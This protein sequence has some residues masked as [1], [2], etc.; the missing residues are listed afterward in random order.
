[1]CS[2]L[3]ACSYWRQANTNRSTKGEWKKPSVQIQRIKANK[4]KT[5]IEIREG[6]TDYTDS[7]Q[8]LLFKSIQEEKP[9]TKSL[10]YELHLCVLHVV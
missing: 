5:F 2:F 9:D 6:K 10:P 1:M 7:K 4:K 3:K 8:T